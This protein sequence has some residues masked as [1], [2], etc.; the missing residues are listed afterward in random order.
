MSKKIFLFIFFVCMSNT[1]LSVFDNRFI[2]LR[3]L[4]YRFVEGLPSSFAVDSFVATASSAFDEDDEDTIGI[5]EIFGRFD[6]NTLAT[7]I[8]K[9]GKPNPLRSDLR[10]RRL[11]FRVDGRLQVQGLSFRC[12][13]S[14]LDNLACGASWVFMRVNSRQLFFLDTKEA[15]MLTMGDR[16]EIERSRRQAFDSIGLTNNH[17]A[18]LGFGD[19]DA[20]LRLGGIWDYKLKCRR[21]YAGITVGALLATGLNRES[22]SAASIP[23][24][25]NGHWGG[26]VSSDLLF[27]LKE[28]IK[29]GFLLNVN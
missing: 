4:P 29:V 28:Y 22:F 8:E 11:P 5:P 14:I 9:T 23:F 6:L 25:G 3:R 13:Q 17:S 18:Q 20:Y 15:Q 16:N 7:A 2:P 26:Y 27:E 1:I 12:H 24:G 10:G 21:I 19:I